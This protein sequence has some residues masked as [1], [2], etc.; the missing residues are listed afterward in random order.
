MNQTYTLKQAMDMLG[1][2]SHLAFHHLKT[3]HPHAFVIVN[4]RSG[5]NDVT[6]YDKQVLDKF[7]QMRGYL[8]KQKGQP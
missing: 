5:R 2:T 3:K 8:K 1:V 7:A 6:L 4:R